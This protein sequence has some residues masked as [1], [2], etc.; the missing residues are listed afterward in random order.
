MSKERSDKIR[1]Y[2]LLGLSLVLVVALYF[3]FVHKGSAVDTVEDPGE[4]SAG[5]PAIPE[6]D[7]N[8]LQGN[9][10]LGR[11]FRG[12]LRDPLRD[13]FVP[14]GAFG[15]EENPSVESGS[16]LPIASLKLKGV[17]AGGT[18]PLALINDQFLRTGDSIDGYQ[19]VRIEKKEVF[20]DSGIEI[21]RLEM[22]KHD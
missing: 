19:V 10:L 6:V 9:R 11:A 20:L 2:V 4:T 22:Q 1:L 16:A 3:R 12:L 21:F 8:A 18:S 13:I 7:F 17:V 5:R 14:G 15:T